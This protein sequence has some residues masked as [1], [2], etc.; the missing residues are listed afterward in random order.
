M[1]AMI[2]RYASYKGIDLPKINARLTFK[3]DSSIGGWA[4]DNVYAMQQAG[5]INGYADGNG[6]V[7]KPKGDA[8]RAEAARM[9]SAF[10][11]L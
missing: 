9:V 8:T 10:L 5:I 11:N 3:D 6:Y 4:K 2:C 1:A 7:F